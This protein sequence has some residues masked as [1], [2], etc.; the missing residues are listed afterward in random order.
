MIKAARKYLIPFLLFVLSGHFFVTAGPCEQ[1]VTYAHHHAI[2]IGAIVERNLHHHTLVPGYNITDRKLR[3]KIYFEE[4]EEENFDLSFAKTYSC[5]RSYFTSFYGK[6]ADFSFVT[7]EKQ[8][9]T[10]THLHQ[11]AC[12]IHLLI[13]VF[14]I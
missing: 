9:N 10:R 2:Q 5:D 7:S 14:R 3:D 13:K 6:P 8:Y 11:Y 12:R 1:F 4:K